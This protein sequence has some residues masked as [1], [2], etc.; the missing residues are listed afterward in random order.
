M[1]DPTNKAELLAQMQSGYASFVALLAPLST[2]QKSVEHVSGEWTIKDILVHLAAWQTRVSLRLEGIARQ[3]E[4]QFELIDTDEKMNAFNDAIFAA[5]RARP[6]DEVEAEFHAS[7]ERLRA[8]VEKAQER[9]LFE[10]GRFAWLKDGLLWQSVAGNTFEHYDE[11]M[12][13]IKAWLAGQ[14]A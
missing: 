5:N 1:S 12:P 10:A 2:E 9:D 7:V 6:L 3:E 4:A 14:Q 13:M 11:H 8:N